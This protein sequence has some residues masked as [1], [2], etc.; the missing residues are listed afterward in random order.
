MP[1]RPT[2]SGLV[3]AGQIPLLNEMVKQADA[4]TPAKAKLLDAG[5]EI[6]Q[7]PDAAEA[8]FM[9][10][11]LVLCTLPHSDPG[12]VAAW[13]RA[14]GNFAFAIQPGIDAFTQKSVGI[15][16]GIIPRLLLYWVCTEAVQKKSPVLEMGNTLSDFMRELDLDPTHGGKKSTAYRLREQATRLFSAT[17]TFQYKFP[18]ARLDMKIGRAQLW[19]TPKRPDQAALWGSCI[20]L[21]TEFF[22]AIK[23]APVPLD[24]RALRAL[25]R[26]PL[27]LDLYSLLTYRAFIATKRH[28]A[29]EIRWIDLQ[30]QFGAEYANVKD[31]RK[32]ASAALSKIEAVLPGLRLERHA[33]GFAVIPG[34]VPA[35]TPRA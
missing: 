31:F 34:S 30:K 29:Q 8:A 12:D 13:G 10:R 6:R 7:D 16:Y 3:R 27:A 23:A 24:T 22:Q 21:T 4:I 26:S 28:A 19:W 18:A 9:A 2:P 1:K 5:A 15:P 14:S 35:I 25:K 11:Q 33:G 17:I 32:K 20:E